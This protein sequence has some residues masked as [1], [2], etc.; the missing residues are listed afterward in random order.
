M[1]SAIPHS[2]IQAFAEKVYEQCL[3]AP[4]DYLFSV[5]E[6]QELTPGKNNLDIT[7]KV[8][9]ELLRTRQLQTLTQGGASV[10]KAVPKEVIEKFVGPFARNEGGGV[11][12]VG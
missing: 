5:D 4:S 3:Q 12:T 8:I 9:N 6:L 7:S 11:W 1:A 10:F 2:T